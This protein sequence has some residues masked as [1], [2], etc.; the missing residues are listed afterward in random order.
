MVK[1]EGSERPKG[2]ITSHA[3]TN[4]SSCPI[5]AQLRCLLS[6]PFKHVLLHLD[7][8]TTSLLI[9]APWCLLPRRPPVH[10]YLGLPMLGPRT[11]RT[12]GT[13]R[14]TNRVRT[15]AHHLLTHYPPTSRHDVRYVRGVSAAW[16]ERDFEGAYVPSALYLF[17]FNHILFPPS[18]PSPIR[19]FFVTALTLAYTAAPPSPPPPAL[20]TRCQV[21]FARTRTRSQRS[22]RSGLPSPARGEGHDQS[23]RGLGAHWVRARACPMAPASPSSQCFHLTDPLA[24]IETVLIVLLH[25][26][27]IA[28]HVGS[29]R[30]VNS[31]PPPPAIPGATNSSLVPRCAPSFFVCPTHPHPHTSIRPDPHPDPPSLSHSPSPSLSIP[32]HSTFPSLAATAGSERGKPAFPPSDARTPPHPARRLRRVPSARGTVCRES[33][34][35]GASETRT[36]ELA[37]PTPSSPLAPFKHL[38]SSSPP[39]TPPHPSRVHTHS[40]SPRVPCVCVCV[41]APSP[42][43]SRVPNACGVGG[44]LSYGEVHGPS[45]LARTR[46]CAPDTWDAREGSSWLRGVS[47]SLG[48]LADAA[49]VC[50][51]SPRAG[52]P[53]AAR[54]TRNG[55]AYLP[56]VLCTTRARRTAISP[57]LSHPSLVPVHAPMSYALL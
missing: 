41:C 12:W 43:T 51:E 31:A 3:K 44:E 35:R 55:R 33:C 48:A 15:P 50:V 6:L 38:R 18:S 16:G 24:R 17:F 20:S 10:A 40:H 52:L 22:P 5:P 29:A 28:T 23:V 47:D 53:S 8:L 2:P 14:L 57:S 21:P 26:L 7:G 11:T 42:H 49:A 1:G 39:Y 19:S 45:L 30:S 13:A 4:T 36:R 32:P 46:C 25:V 9:L 56:A 27:T 34:V 37:S 54:V